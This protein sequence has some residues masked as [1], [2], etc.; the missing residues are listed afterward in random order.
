MLISDCRELPPVSIVMAQIPFSR[1]GDSPQRLE[2]LP[3][4]DLG[5][6]DADMVNTG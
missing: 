4:H 6:H 5:R 1:F 2:L 3:L